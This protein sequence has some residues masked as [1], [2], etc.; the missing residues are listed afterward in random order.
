[1]IVMMIPKKLAAAQI[2]APLQ[3]RSDLALILTNAKPM[4]RAAA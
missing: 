3:P 2:A 1:L 4:R